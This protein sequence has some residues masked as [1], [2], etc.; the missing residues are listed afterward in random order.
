V[1]EAAGS[2]RDWRGSLTMQVAALEAFGAS[3]EKLHTVAAAHAVAAA[4]SI[5]AP[6]SP[7]AP[8]QC[9]ER[10]VVRVCALVAACGCTA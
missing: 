5:G 9:A 8:G 4:D 2:G 7:P 10:C 6:P 1:A 3:L